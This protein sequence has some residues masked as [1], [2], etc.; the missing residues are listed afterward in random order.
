MTIEERQKRTR[1]GQYGI[2]LTK[3]PPTDTPPVPASQATA[4]GIDHRCNNETPLASARGGIFIFIL[5]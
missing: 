2:H 3:A 5:V 1:R 4:Y